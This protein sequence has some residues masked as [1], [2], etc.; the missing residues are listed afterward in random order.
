MSIEASISF[1]LE[2]NPDAVRLFCLIGMMPGG[3]QNYDLSELWPKD[4]WYGHHLNKLIDSSLVQRKAEI[5]VISNKEHVSYC[6]LPFMN[7]YSETLNK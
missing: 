6:L 1:L 4:D 5:N 2:K 3:L 7:Y